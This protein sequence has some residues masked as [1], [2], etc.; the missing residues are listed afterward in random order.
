[1]SVR[2]TVRDRQILKERADRA[3]V[4]ASRRNNFSVGP[5][6]SSVTNGLRE[7]R[8]REG[9]FASTRDACAPQPPGT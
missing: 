9:A 6:V 2:F 8:E 7:V 5:G 4:S 1:M 3:L